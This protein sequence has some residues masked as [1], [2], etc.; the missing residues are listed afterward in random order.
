M[1]AEEA[2][3]LN[4]KMMNIERV[5]SLF[6]KLITRLNEKGQYHK[7]QTLKQHFSH[8]S[9]EDRLLIFSNDSSV[10][11]AF[12]EALASHHYFFRQPVTYKDPEKKVIDEQWASNNFIAFKK[13]VHTP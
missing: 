10:S 11:L 13:A 4:E 9:A 3:L 12:R 8:M 1:S 7:A 5:S 6:D 2:I